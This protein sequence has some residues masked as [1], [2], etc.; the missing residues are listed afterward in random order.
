MTKTGVVKVLAEV[1]SD[2]AGFGTPLVRATFLLFSN[3]DPPSGTDLLGPKSQTI[4]LDGDVAAF[5]SET[6]WTIRFTVTDTDTDAQV[7]IA[8]AGTIVPK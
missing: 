8:A 6:Q 3:E 7:E 2:T 5:P 4:F 1:L